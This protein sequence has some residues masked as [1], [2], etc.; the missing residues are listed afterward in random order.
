MLVTKCAFRDKGYNMCCFGDI[1]RDSENIQEEWLSTSAK[2]KK[3]HALSYRHTK[4][5]HIFIIVAYLQMLR[6]YGTSKS[7]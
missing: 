3:K 4:C 5:H 2:T 1:K 6:G 7:K